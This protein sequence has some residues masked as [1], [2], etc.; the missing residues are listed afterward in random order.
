M[1]R[2]GDDD[3]DDKPEVEEDDDRMGA[4]NMN[5]MGDGQSKV[6]Q[7]AR[8]LMQDEEE[9]A[10]EKAG[11]GNEEAPGNVIRM[12]K[13]G[14]GKKKKGGPAARAGGDDAK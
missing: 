3:D 8:K 6:V 1:I 2:D 13:L 7:E 10:G 4:P 11:A 14:R 5:M 9:N 12:G